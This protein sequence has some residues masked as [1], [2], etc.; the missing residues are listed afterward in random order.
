MAIVVFFIIF[1]GLSWLLGK[2][3]G[4]FVEGLLAV[5]PIMIITIVALSY[6]HYASEAAK[7][8]EAAKSA[9]FTATTT[10]SQEQT[11]VDI[12]VVGTGKLRP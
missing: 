12:P 6:F 9:K 8:R 1:I 3:G 10:T 7:E 5:S 11:P 4:G 2:T